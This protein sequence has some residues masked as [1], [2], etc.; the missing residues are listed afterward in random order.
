MG[1]SESLCKQSSASCFWESGHGDCLV[2]PLA[3]CDEVH[4]SEQL[5]LDNRTEFSVELVTGMGSLLKIGLTISADADPTFVTID[6]IWS[7]S[8][9]SYWNDTHFEVVKVRV[10]DVIMA[11]NDVSGDGTEI[12]DQI[13]SAGHSLYLET[14]VLEVWPRH[15]VDALKEVGL[16]P[17]RGMVSPQRPGTVGKDKEFLRARGGY[18]LKDGVSPSD[19]RRDALLHLDEEEW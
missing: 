19:F 4:G 11:A 18:E 10:G 16:N 1:T 5:I 2:Q 7:P 12:M 9:I 15:R 6:K 8:L 13:A 17:A 14:L 3:P